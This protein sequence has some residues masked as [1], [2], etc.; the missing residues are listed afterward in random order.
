MLT[1]TVNYIPA[2]KSEQVDSVIGIWI[3]IRILGKVKGQHLADDTV[4]L[5]G[6]RKSAV[7]VTELR[8]LMN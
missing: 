6:E 4:S 5:L 2:N 1:F 3:G 7:S 8:D